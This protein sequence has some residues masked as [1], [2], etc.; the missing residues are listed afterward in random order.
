ML[1]VFAAW[2]QDA[3][4]KSAGEVLQSNFGAAPVD[5][6]GQDLDKTGRP[7]FR[8]L[9]SQLPESAAQGPL[10]LTNLTSRRFYR[11]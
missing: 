4:E 10:L 9:H 8:E 1:W 3:A 6:E 7:H 11:D 5:A 2:S